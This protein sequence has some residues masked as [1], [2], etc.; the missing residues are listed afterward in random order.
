MASQ[1]GHVVE[2]TPPH[3]SDLQPIELVWAIVKGEVGRQYTTTTTFPAV[4]TRL[5]RA[6]NNL[7]ESAIRGCMN[8]AE[9][10][11]HQLHTIYMPLKAMLKLATHQTTTV[12]VLQRT[13]N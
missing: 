13:T 3:H 6:F 12:K 11:V 5:K 4:L 10:K 2:F 9:E 1:K 7:S 8:A